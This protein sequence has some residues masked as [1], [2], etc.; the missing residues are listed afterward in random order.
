[1]GSSC[2]KISAAFCVVAL[3]SELSFAANVNLK[4]NAIQP[5]VSGAV[6]V[7][8]II[9]KSDG[10]Y[11]S[12]E[13]GNSSW[14]VVTLRGKAVGPT[15][16]LSIPTGATQITVGKGPDYIPQTITTNLANAGQTYTVN[17][18]LQ[19]A[20]DLFGKGWRAGD[21]HV[22]FYH[23]EFETNRTPQD[24]WTMCAAAGMNF[25]SF[26]E[27]HCGATTLTRQQMLDTWK[28]YENSECK[29]W[30]GVEEPKN[31]WGHH[32]NI[33]YDPWALRSALPY[34]WGIHSVHEQG[35]V[36][37]PVHPD[38]FYPTRSSGGLF[39]W[40]NQL[41]W[42]P[43]SALTG[44][45]LDGWSG[46]SDEAF[47]NLTLTSYFKLLS[48]NYKIPLLADSDFCMDRINNGNKGLG[49]WMNFFQLEGNPLSRASLCN[50]MR[51]GRVMCTTGPLVLFT[52]DNAMSGDT[53]PADGATRTVRI[54]ASYRFNPWTLSTSN[55]AG[56]DSCKIPQIDLIRNGQ[57]IQTWTPNAP[58]SVVQKTINETSNNTYYMARVVGNDGVWMA[59][60]ASPIYFENTARPR[61]PQ[62]FKS[63]IKGRLYDAK[64][65]VALTGTVSCLQYSK[66]NWTIPTDSQG[67][68]RAYVPIDADLVAK[69][70]SGRTLSRNL[71]NYEP[72]YSLCNYLADNY[73]NDKGPAIDA[74]Q[75]VVQEMKWE[76][77]IGLQ[78][79]GSYVRTNLSGDAALSNFS[80]VSAPSPF[81][82]KQKTEI[83]MLLID[84]TVVQTGDTIDYAAI[85]RQTQGAP[86]TEE[87]SIEWRGWD[88][89]YPRMF[90][91]YGT[92]FKYDNNA[93]S[94][95]NLGGGFYLRQ[96]SV[97][98]PNWVTNATPTTAAI[99]MHVTARGNPEEANLLIP[100][101]PTKR[102]LLVSTTWDGFPAAWGE[103]GIGPCNFYRETTFTTR[104]ADYRGMTVRLKLNGQQIDLN[105]K[106]DT[107][108][109][110]D[111]DDA[112]F[113]E[114]F[115][116]DGQCEPQYRN[117][118][119]RDPVRSQP[120]EPDYSGVPIQ[121][122]PDTTPPTVALMEPFSGDS[123]SGTM[124]FFYFIDDAGL[125]GA[126]NAT[127]LIDGNAVV[128]HT[129][130]N[131]I[132]LNLSGGNHTWQI[133]G[134]DNAGNSALSEL[135]LIN[136]TGG[137]NSPIQLSAPTRL[138]SGKFQ[139]TFNT[140]PGLSYIVQSATLLTNWQSF[141]TTNATT[142][143]VTA[144][145]LNATN[146]MK[147]YRVIGP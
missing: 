105:P 93:A 104:Y 107:A 66:T 100:L 70:N 131:P 44:H 145:D 83:V 77:P 6:C 134:Y 102:E 106:N 111:A 115:Y 101:G 3:S 67:R 113:V 33:L 46:V 147:I 16:V 37:Y 21:A 30:N 41:K 61:Q 4:I 63:L 128:S 91:K 42:L 23:G 52:I 119:M 17:F 141:L 133:R 137:T 57:V 96:G 142:N 26:A 132:V 56:N 31:E 92:V 38:R 45:L 135:R 65:G 123:V 112:I 90:T 109:V 40:N 36:N 20:L 54:E 73:P 55:F 117:I 68:F 139:F 143:S 121:N 127:L 18:S 85:F 2:A 110:A 48:M 144:I 5:G 140:T 129:T 58:T 71:M 125:S 8:A 74:M 25:A 82:G 32:A 24:A 51:R 60:Y 72:A 120:A 14:P 50:A 126:S 69:D 75:N 49:F 35:G 89:N 15:T 88:P 97:V 78:F 81:S 103:L 22:H 53:L 86:P 138:A 59:G 99:Q 7:R 62:V 11:V 34:N 28:V 47:N 87:L 80:I 27:E 114:R 118:P 130:N 136:V 43:I 84:K 95:V 124:R 64:T 29:L 13:W 79:A 1:M 39:P 10:S 122:P 19:P 76:F 94:L 98:V 116:Y 146:S 9:K 108:H 12:G